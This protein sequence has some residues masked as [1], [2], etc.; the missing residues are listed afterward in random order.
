MRLSPGQATPE[1]KKEFRAL[2]ASLQT[3]VERYVEWQV[4]RD[5]VAEDVY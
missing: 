5:A 4:K 3:G 1:K 2:L